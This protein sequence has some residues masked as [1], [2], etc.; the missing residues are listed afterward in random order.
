MQLGDGETRTRPGTAAAAADP[1]AGDQVEDDVSTAVDYDLRTDGARLDRE[2]S[3]ELAPAV[4]RGAAAT[5]A[6]IGN[7]I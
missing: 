5:G 7:G 4:S 2:A 6:P 1:D 3:L